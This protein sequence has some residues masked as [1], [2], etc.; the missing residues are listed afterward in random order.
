[1]LLEMYLE[2][3]LM[4]I[5]T[6]TPSLLQN[7]N[8]KYLKDLIAGLEKKHADFLKKSPCQPLYC[9]S[10]VSSCMNGFVPL[11]HPTPVGNSIETT[12]QSLSK[13]APAPVG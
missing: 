13:P 5:V 9:L 12:T 2:G 3:Q 4:D 11:G 8:T 1:M 6:P 7:K 10:G